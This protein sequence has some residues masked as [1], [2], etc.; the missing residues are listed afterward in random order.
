[1]AVEVVLALVEEVE[2]WLERGLMMILMLM[3]NRFGW[4][5]G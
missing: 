5:G 4:R 2:V 1:M 3:I